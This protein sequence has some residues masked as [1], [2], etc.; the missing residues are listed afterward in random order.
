MRVFCRAVPYNNCKHTYNIQTLAFYPFLDSDEALWSLMNKRC[1]LL[2]KNITK[3]KY[4]EILHY[5]SIIRF[6]LF[7]SFLLLLQRYFSFYALGNHACYFFLFIWLS[8]IENGINLN[9]ELLKILQNVLGN[10]WLLCTHFRYLFYVLCFY[11]I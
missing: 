7:T 8:I 5:F 10:D 4:C 2:T 11:L 9:F 3:L 6:V 1:I